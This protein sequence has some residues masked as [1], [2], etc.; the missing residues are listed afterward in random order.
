[1][2]RSTPLRDEQCGKLHLFPGTLPV[3]ATMLPILNGNDIL[4]QMRQDWSLHTYWMTAFI[5]HS[6][7]SLSGYNGYSDQATIEDFCRTSRFDIANHYNRSLHISEPSPITDPNEIIY[8]AGKQL[9]ELLDQQI[10]IVKAMAVKAMDNS[11]LFSDKDTYNY[12]QARV[13]LK[14]GLI[15]S[16]D[17]Y[18]AYDPIPEL[19]ANGKAVMAVIAN[20]YAATGQNFDQATFDRFNAATL[21]DIGASAESIWEDY[22]SSITVLINKELSFCKQGKSKKVVGDD[23]LAAI[24]VAARQVHLQAFRV[25]AVFAY[26]V[27]K[28][29]IVAGKAVEFAAN[30]E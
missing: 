26:S 15:C 18:D 17:D 3:K 7:R 4:C 10:S 16:S 24:A 20:V 6:M 22:L 28:G 13:L 25:G 30:S 29:A 14:N 27:T 11:N 8:P 19:V 5:Q 12:V 2:K 9:S 1:M 23:D 21:N